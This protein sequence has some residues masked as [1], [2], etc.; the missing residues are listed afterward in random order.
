MPSLCLFVCQRR[1]VW[2]VDPYYLSLHLFFPYEIMQIKS[3]FLEISPSPTFTR[4]RITLMALRDDVPNV[5]SMAE[6]RVAPYFGPNDTFW[7]NNDELSEVDET[8]AGTFLFEGEPYAHAGIPILPSSVLRFRVERGDFPHSSLAFTGQ[9]GHGRGWDLWTDAMLSDAE[10]LE[11][12]KAS[13]IAD[14][15]RNTRELTIPR[16]VHD[17]ALLVSRWSRDTHTFVTSWG[18]FTPTI[19]D[20]VQLMCLN[21]FGE[22]NP[23][24]WVLSEDEVKLVT[25]L[26]SG[27]TAAGKIASRYQ[28]DGLREEFPETGK[29]C[30]FVSLLRYYFRDF[31]LQDQEGEASF[32]GPKCKDSACLAAFLLSWLSRFIF[33]GPPDDGPCPDL[34]PLAVWLSCGNSFPLAALFLGTLYHE[35]DL[36]HARMERSVGRMSVVSPV[37]TIF[38]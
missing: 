1:D 8:P 22:H 2:G 23:G 28:D 9:T 6:W 14:A 30:T 36:A 10:F 7:A 35:L 24:S 32:N 26:R 33:P 37:N 29:K 16:D 31:P 38:L 3:D 15:V 5:P 4:G 17:L 13:R 12:L 11:T 21:V 27:V 34:I 20:V 18:E 19:E 25:K